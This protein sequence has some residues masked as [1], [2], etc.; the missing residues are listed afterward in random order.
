[1]TCVVGMIGADGSVLIG[2]DS[3]GV[4]GLDVLVRSDKKVFKKGQF[5]FGFAGSFREMQVINHAFKIPKPP[6]N[7]EKDFAY[8][9]SKFV[10]K[11]RDA[12]KKAGALKE[13]RGVH[14]MESK[15]LV[16]FRGQIYVIEVD[17]QVGM[18]AQKYAAAGC[19]EAYSLGALYSMTDGNP[20]E[21]LEDSR[22]LLSCA[23]EAAVEFSGGVRP[24][25]NFVELKGKE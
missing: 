11:M 10:P 3:A 13:T 21:N 1:M 8:M 18:A 22:L 6:V 24:P 19:G 15:A 4:S 17:F 16:G 7:P 9:V 2:A 20:C 25:F 14:E 23:L 12:L 5:I